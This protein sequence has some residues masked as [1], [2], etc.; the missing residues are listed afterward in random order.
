[1]AT[2]G[3]AS[4]LGSTAATRPLQLRHRRD[5][6]AWPLDHAGRRCWGLR[7]PLS[8]RY[9]QLQE[10]EFFLLQQL[11]GQVTL[12]GLR[13]QF[14]EQFAPL[15]I[16][17]EQL[18]SFLTMLH[19]E[20]LVLSE[21]SGQGEHLVEHRR[22]QRMREFKGKLLS[23]LAIRFRGID[24]D[25]MLDVVAPWFSWM[26]SPL[27]V[28]LCLLLASG[29]SAL[30]A[31][32]YETL[33]RRLPDFQAFFSAENAIWI[34]VAVMLAKLLHE[35]G[36]AVAC[37]HYG[38]ECHEMGVML[39]AF[40][41]CLYVNVSDA[42]MLPNRW[43]RIAISGAGM[44]VEL[45][46]ASLCTFLWWF[47]L[48]G[49]LNSMCLNLMF[50]CSVSTLLF[51]GNP[52][53]RYD[54]YYIFS[55]LLG[56]PNLRQQAS[57]LMQA[58][59][60]NWYLGIDQAN[61][62]SLPDRLRWLLTVY[63]AAA[64]VYRVF[65]VVAILWFVHRV[66]RPYRLEVLAEML[67]VTTVAGMVVM[68]VVQMVQFVRDPVRSRDVQWNRFF[69]LTGLS[70][71]CLLLIGLI[72]LPHRVEVPA[73]I[74]PLES[75]TVYV[76]VPGQV[77]W[78]VAPGTQVARGDELARLR[79]EELEVELLQLDGEHKRQERRVRNLESRQVSN[80]S[81]GDELPTARERLADLA[82]RLAQRQQQ[83][84][85]LKI[86][87]PV[88]GTVLPPRLR[89]DV[90]PEGALPGWEGTPL[91]EQNRGTWLTT[92]TP[93]CVL[94]DP[95]Q[96]EVLLL[97]EQT[98]VELVRREQKVR[99]RF[100]QLP[101]QILEGTL[102][103]IAELDLDVA[104]PELIAAGEVPVTTDRSGGQRLLSTYYQGRVL[105]AESP[106]SRLLRGGAGRARVEVDPQ[107]LLDRLL[108]Y[109]GR[110]FRFEL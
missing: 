47:T 58:R 77:T 92:Q 64:I 16:S 24:P 2:A 102:K 25:A 89:R 82:G 33:A 99:L 108:R 8:L 78:T 87:A 12:A 54:G 22:E 14:E 15:R 72:P 42:W 60:E 59:F 43:H 55:D 84:D 11:N 50:V 71:G 81:A 96:M 65:V 85:R 66:L 73:V 27:M 67:T 19:R 105:F 23:L 13:E 76:T 74:Q 100:G 101:G 26:F 21:A 88:A 31:F 109:L 9:Y 83:Y 45:V 79:N 30:A 93:L 32:N 40:T 80:Q 70:L 97:I 95:Q 56:I 7:D 1:M 98:Q 90:P 68:P 51:N 4:A 20:G 35:F 91:D 94:G 61:P 6:E 106:S 75:R 53:L 29:A 104:P 52:L 38:G 44:Y 39:L 62:R 18:Q 110:T 17:I 34:A 46:L 103:E 28:G 57:S 36:H 48:P 37:K 107:S 69:I 63:W 3:F 86:L 5:L 41:P 10:E 49:P